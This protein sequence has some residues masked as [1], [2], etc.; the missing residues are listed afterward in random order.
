MTIKDAWNSSIMFGTLSIRADFNAQLKPN[1]PPWGKLG[2]SY[3]WLVGGL[4]GTLRSRPGMRTCHPLRA[5]LALLLT[6]FVHE[7]PIPHLSSRKS[8][9][10]LAGHVSFYLL[11]F[12]LT[13]ILQTKFWKKKYSRFFNRIQISRYFSSF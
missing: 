6:D 4:Y 12:L 3:R 8:I 11:F 5:F 13:Y 2:F 7:K 1:S 10:I 9:G